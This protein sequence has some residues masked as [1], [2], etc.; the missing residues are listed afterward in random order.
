VIG[1]RDDDDGNAGGGPN[2]IA[3]EA[4]SQKSNGGNTIHAY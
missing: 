3:E 4:K 1:A 2:K